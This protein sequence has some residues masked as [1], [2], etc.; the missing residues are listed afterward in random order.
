T[1]ASL[2]NTGGANWKLTGVTADPPTA[3]GSYSLTVTAKDSY[4]GIDTEDPTLDVTNVPPEI[5]SCSFNPASIMNDSADSATLECDISDIN[6]NP[7]TVTADLSS[8]GGAAA[9]SLT[10][11]GGSTWQLTGVTAVP[12]TTPGSYTAAVTATDA[13]G[14][15]GGGAAQ[16]TVENT[17]PVISSCSFTPGSLRNDSADSA[18]L[19]CDISDINGD[20]LT[21]SVNL[22]AIGGAAAAS[23]TNT[24]GSTWR[25]TSITADP[26]TTPDSYSLTVTA[27]DSYGDTDTENAQLDISNTPPDIV[28]CSFNPGSIPADGATPTTLECEVTDINSNTLVVKVDLSPIGGSATT[29]LS[30]ITGTDTFQRT[31]IKAGPLT[32]FGIHNLTVT[33]TDSF[34]D[35]DTETPA[36]DVTDVPPVITG[37]S[38]DPSSIVSTGFPQTDLKCTVTDINQN[39]STVEVDLALIGGPAAAQLT[40]TSGSTWELFGVAAP[41]GTPPNLYSLTVTATD[42][43]G[44]TGTFGAGL[45][46]GDPVPIS[47]CT[48]GNSILPH[49]MA[50]T[51]DGE[52]FY[53]LEAAADSAGNIFVTNLSNNR[54]EKYDSDC[55]FVMNWG[56]TGSG[57]GQFNQPR[58]IVFNEAD[59]LLYISDRYD[60]VRKFDTDGNYVG[61]WKSKG[62]VSIAADSQG[63]IFVSS[64]SGG[65]M[66]LKYNSN[67]LLLANWNTPKPG[68]IAVADSGDVLVVEPTAH[69]IHRYDADGQ[70][71]NDIGSFGSADGQIRDP[72][73][74]TVNGSFIYVA[75]KGTNRIEMFSFDGTFLFNFGQ[76]GMEEGK[77]FG[78]T[79][80]T[81]LP[82][83]NIVVIEQNNDRIQIFSD[84]P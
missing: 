54:I 10:N 38:F 26:T 62:I 52:L 16:L 64:T 19:E 73:G 59:G 39:L 15:T 14:D 42:N 75:S 13:Y 45:L 29:P 65:G 34:G 69:T 55:N 6:G 43:S 17:P 7:M 80:I 81:R 53:P 31:G 3:P 83:N 24:G 23:L 63:N 44:G 46:V 67:G 8:I 56:T 5:S 71:I 47:E 36:L 66:V 68:G 2:T 1:A 27:T 48:A 30:K 70:L 4:G 57:P 35:S 41:L 21:A 37:C 33:A 50:P 74:I 22:T 82:N 51:P 12:T 40:N 72:Y 11:T 28:S 58:G 79:D 18:T 60:Y 61:R 32:P 20:P 78:L 76:K 77:I 9:A 25:L 49:L 84:F